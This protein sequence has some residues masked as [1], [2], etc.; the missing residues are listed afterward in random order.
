MNLKEFFNMK[1]IYAIHCDTEEKAIK[2][3][4]AFDGMGKTWRTG[5]KYV[6]KTYWDNY[7]EKTMYSNFGTFEL[8]DSWVEHLDS[9]IEFDEIEDFKN[10]ITPTYKN[11]T[12]MPE[13]K[14]ART[15]FTKADLHSWDIVVFRDGKAGIVR[16][17]MDC[18]IMKKWS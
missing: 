14:P 3:L 15:T 18:I 5:D 2:L 4:K 17:D 6:T 11:L 16:L 8:E 9:V 7:R 13:I 10:N 12:P 1:Q